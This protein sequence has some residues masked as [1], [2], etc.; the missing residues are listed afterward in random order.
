MMPASVLHLLKLQRLGLDF[1]YL[2]LNS[3]RVVFKGLVERVVD[4]LF[5]VEV[6]HLLHKILF[7]ALEELLEVLL[8]AL[9][10]HRLK[11]VQVLD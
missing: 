9:V 6:G 4:L 10:F 2:P 1:S 3:L 5:L 11:K 7:V 8:I